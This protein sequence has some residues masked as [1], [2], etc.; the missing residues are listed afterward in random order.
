MFNRIFAILKIRNIWICISFL[1]LIIILWGICFKNATTISSVGVEDNKLYAWGFV[2]AKNNEQPSFTKSYTDVLD[3]YNGIYIGNSTDKVIYLTF[4]EGYENGYTGQILDVLKKE[5]I[6][7][8]FFVTGDYVKRNEEL[9]GRMINEG[10][11]VGNHSMNH[12]SFPTLKSEIKIKEELVSLDNLVMDKFGYKMVYFRPPKG[13]YSSFAMKNICELG[14]TTVLWSFAYDDW[15]VKKQNREEYAKKI[16][17]N[18]FH[19]GS[20]MLL[21]AVSK[22]NANILESIICE[23]KTQ[24]YEFKSLNDFKR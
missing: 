11:I 2:R 3:E 12:P 8:A 13:E 17:T 5:N 21:H 22:D 15:D 4:D 7:A 19:N 23:A 18:N 14:Y 10:H 16:I 20:I 1:I 9:V 6:P 24:G